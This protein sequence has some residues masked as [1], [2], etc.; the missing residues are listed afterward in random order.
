MEV[1]TKDRFWLQKV[2]RV[3]SDR[4][5]VYRSGWMELCI[6]DCGTIIKLKEK[7]PSG[8]QRVISTSVSSCQIRQMALEFTRM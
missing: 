4:D 8:M 3:K 6:R 1:C 5:T 7:E 2:D